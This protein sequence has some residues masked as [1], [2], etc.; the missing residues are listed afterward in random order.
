MQHGTKAVQVGP[1]I[2]PLAAHPFRTH[3]V[4]R[5]DHSAGTHEALAPAAA[6]G[7]AEVGQHRSAVVAQQDVVGRH[8]TVH[9]ALPVRIVERLGDLPHDAQRKGDRV[10]TAVN[11]AHRATGQVFHGDVVVPTGMAD[12]VDADHMT[13]LQPGGN[14]RL[15]QE[16]LGKRRVREQARQQD[17]QRNITVDRFLPG[18]IDGC[19]AAL[20]QLP[21]QAIARYLDH[22]SPAGQPQA[23]MTWIARQHPGPGT[24][25]VKA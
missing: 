21:Q 12:V 3:V 9:D 24:Q 11:R 23:A 25:Q 4:G 18:Q 14:A 22:F 16:M 5:A 15:A 17:L 6:A 8:V 19:H 10:G 20:P 2:H 13:M 7:D 1:A